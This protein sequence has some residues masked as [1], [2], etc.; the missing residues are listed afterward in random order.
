MSIRITD[1][2]SAIELQEGRNEEAWH[3]ASAACAARSIT[4]LESNSR[5]GGIEVDDD[6]DEAGDEEEGESA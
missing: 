1:S 4:L 5:M 6:G 3:D 2:P